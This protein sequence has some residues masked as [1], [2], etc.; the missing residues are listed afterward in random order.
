MS[1]QHSIQFG[2]DLSEAIAYCPLCA[3]DT[4]LEWSLSLQ[5]L[6]IMS[7]GNFQPN[8]VQMAVSSCTSLST[9]LP[10]CHVQ[11][12]KV[13]ENKYKKRIHLK[14]QRF[15]ESMVQEER[16][17]VETGT[18]PAE[19]PRPKQPSDQHMVELER[20]SAKP[21]CSCGLTPR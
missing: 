6:T 19:A 8:C 17:R 12:C 2:Y 13:R 15:Q 5:P 1:C 18:G 16:L 14:H 11:C 20:N 9:T 21:A 4:T 7:S 10:A 3:G